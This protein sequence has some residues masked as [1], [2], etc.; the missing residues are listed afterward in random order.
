[1]QI[2]RLALKFFLGIVSFLCVSLFAKENTPQYTLSICAIFK[3]EAPYLKEWL[4]YHKLVG[5][6]HFYLY[7]NESEDDYLSLLAPYVEQG[8]VTLI[9]WPNQRSSEWKNRTSAW[10][11]T[12]Q[13]S[14]FEDAFQRSKEESKWIAAIDIDEF[15][16][17]VKTDLIVDVLKKYDRFFPGVEIFWRVYGTSGC[18]S[19]PEGQLLI[20]TLNKRSFPDCILNSSYKTILKPSFYQ[21]F[22]WPPHQCSYKQGLH[23]YRI[24]RSELVINHYIN[25]SEDY[26]FSMKI[27]NKETMENLRFDDQEIQKMLQVGNDLYDEEQLIHRFIPK[28]KEKIKNRLR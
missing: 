13:V 8:E 23:S 5:V 25:R 11:Y 24:D 15:I 19:I 22:V 2:G 20:E 12:T 9:D 26:F 17:P 27:K 7:N 3:N 18:K 10:V 14:A 1:M 4:E 6:D 21:S 28:L 16:V